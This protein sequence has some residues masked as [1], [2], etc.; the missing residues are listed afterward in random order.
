MIIPST[1]NFLVLLF[2]KGEALFC[3]LS[4]WNGSPGTLFSIVT[5]RAASTRLKT[6]AGIAAARL[7]RPRRPRVAFEKNCIV[8]DSKQKNLEGTEKCDAGTE[9]LQK[10]DTSARGKKVRTV[11]DT[12]LDAG[13]QVRPHS[14]KYSPIF[15]LL[16]V[17]T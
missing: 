1:S 5:G 4:F 12:C 13:V 14:L 17:S 10:S 2:K 15:T 6:S 7:E 8:E 9:L 3:S 16:L 11:I